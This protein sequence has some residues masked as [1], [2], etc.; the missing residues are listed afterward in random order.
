MDS[1]DD[2]TENHLR[3]GR[4]TPSDLR[5]DPDASPE[6]VAAIAAALQ[7]PHESSDDGD[8]TPP[9]DGWMGRTWSF[10]GR[11][12]LVTNRPARPADPLPT[13]PWVAADRLDRSHRNR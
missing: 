12:E 13:D 11:Y 5:I 4:I 8:D 1:T 7:A 3:G 9:G 2:G 10:A 6:T